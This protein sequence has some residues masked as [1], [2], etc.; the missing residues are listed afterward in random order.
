MVNL[1]EPTQVHRVILRPGVPG[2]GSETSR[3]QGGRSRLVAEE[4]L[5]RSGQGPAL[6]PL[7]CC[8]GESDHTTHSLYKSLPEGESEA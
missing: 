7:F 2:L 6:P 1:F 3:G 8:Q 4:Q 5:G